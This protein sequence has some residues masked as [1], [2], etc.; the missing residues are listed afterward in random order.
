V[1][2]V[3]GDFG[4]SG[5]AFRESAKLARVWYIRDRH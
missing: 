5:R 2:R 4:V 3:D 1:K